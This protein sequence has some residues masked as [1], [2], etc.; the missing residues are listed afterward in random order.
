MPKGGKRPGAGRPRN[1]ENIGLDFLPATPGFTAR[2]F[3]RRVAKHSRVPI[4]LRIKAAKAV[5]PYLHARGEACPECAKAIHQLNIALLTKGSAMQPN[6]PTPVEIAAAASMIRAAR[7]LIE[8][9][10]STR[11]ANAAAIRAALREGVEIA[12]ELLIGPL[13]SVRIITVGAE[14]EVAATICALDL[15]PALLA[16]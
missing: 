6:E 7:I 11:P 16:G 9:Q 14:G 15:N 12:A 4:A 3:L 2:Q 10:M 5:M 8:T 13:P 1:P